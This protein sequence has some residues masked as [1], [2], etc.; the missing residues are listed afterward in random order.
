ML[1]IFN[2]VILSLLNSG[3]A[4]ETGWGRVLENE[5]KVGILLGLQKLTALLLQAHG[6]KSGASDLR[7]GRVIKIVNC[8]T[9]SSCKTKNFTSNFLG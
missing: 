1:I 6:K 5:E 7:V 3:K 8:A 4:S 2:P 9:L